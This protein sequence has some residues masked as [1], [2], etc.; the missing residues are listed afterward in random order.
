MSSKFD[1]KIL[2]LGGL[3]VLE[4]FSLPLGVLTNAMIASSAG[5]D[6]DKLEH[7][8]VLT[9]KQDDGTDIAAAIVPIYTV[10]GATATIIECEV[11]C[12][13]APDGGDKHFTVD[14]KK[15]NEGSPSPATVLDTILDSDTYGTGVSE[16]ADCEVGTA[17]ISSATLAA[18]DTLVVVIAIAGSTGNQGQG[19]V[20]TV[21]LREDA[22]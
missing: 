7:Q 21:T 15:C 16:A 11:V 9:Y 22:E 1:E 17:V 10:R 6:A 19:L 8:H 2:A 13:D 14:L 3:T 18:E 5:V 4:S 12:I 20:V